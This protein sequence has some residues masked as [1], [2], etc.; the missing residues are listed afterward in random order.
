LRQVVSV[1]VPVVTVVVV[2]DVVDREVVVPV[3]DVV[4]WEVVEDVSLRVVV[5]VGVVV[6]VVVVFSAQMPQEKSQR[7]APVQ[8]GQYTV[9]QSARVWLHMARQSG[10][11]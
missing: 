3:V 7:W 9:S 5:E 2:P 11:L 6:S 4:D 8:V 1:V 10:Y